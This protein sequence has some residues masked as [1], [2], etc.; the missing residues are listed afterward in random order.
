MYGDDGHVPNHALTLL[1]KVKEYVVVVE[2]MY[3][4]EEILLF[5]INY[6]NSV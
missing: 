2:A 5:H 6:N 3:H 4:C 1:A